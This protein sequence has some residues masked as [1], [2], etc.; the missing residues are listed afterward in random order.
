MV[1]GFWGWGREGVQG[2][3]RRASSKLSHSMLPGK[4]SVNSWFLLL[5]SNVQQKLHRQPETAA[6]ETAQGLPSC[7]LR[8]GAPLAEVPLPPL[9]TGERL[10][11]T[12]G[13][14]GVCVQEA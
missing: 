4:R 5:L 10:K 2:G 14:W 6:H 8:Q 1:A 11:P 7:P 13:V 12:H 3:A 9:Q